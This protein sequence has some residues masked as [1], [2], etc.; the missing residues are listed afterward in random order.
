MYKQAGIYVRK[1]KPEDIVFNIYFIDLE[2]PWII[3]LPGLPQYI[4]KQWYLK[5]LVQSY[6]VLNPYYPGS[7]HSDGQFNISSLVQTVESSLRLLEAGKF[8]DFFEG[9][10]YRH[11]GVLDSIWGL[12][13]GSNVLFDYMTRCDKR[14]I[15][16]VLFSPL[17]QLSNPTQNKYWHQKLTFLG[18]EVYRNIYRGYNPKELFRWLQIMENRKVKNTYKNG[19]VIFG[20]N[21][22]L[23]DESFLKEKFPNFEIKAIDNL[24][25]EVDNLVNA[26]ITEGYV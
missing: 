15:K 25:H 26:Y 11:N 9:V 13:F 22:R 3:L 16:P 14:L 5:K 12:S 1:T 8:Y 7:F 23:V 21:D 17:I 4:H 10:T 24:A 19:V 6:C 20:K 2:L 18:S